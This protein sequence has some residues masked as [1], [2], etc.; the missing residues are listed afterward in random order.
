MA[1]VNIFNKPAYNMNANG[2]AK[3]LN[4]AAKRSKDFAMGL[5]SEGI[6]GN[7]TGRDV[8]RLTNGEA[9]GM[10]DKKGNLTDFG[11]K[12]MLESIKKVFGLSTDEAAK[13]V[14]VGQIFKKG[15]AD[16]ARKTAKGFETIA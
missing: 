13:K 7:V 4:E 12:L 14:T 11:T 9:L 10:Y 2:Y 16:S 15:I 6:R 8:I 5:V 3:V 1:P